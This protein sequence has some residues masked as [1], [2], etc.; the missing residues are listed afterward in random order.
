MPPTSELFE[1]LKHSVLK[2]GLCAMEHFGKDISIETKQDGSKVSAADFAVNKILHDELTPLNK[3]YAWLSEESPIEQN[4]LDASH[5]W[6]IDPIDGTNGFLSHKPDWTIVAALIKENSPVLAAVYNPVKQELYMAEK[7]KGAFLNDHPIKVSNTRKLENAHIISS[8]GH[9]NRSF[10]TEPKPA[11]RSWKH[12]MAY[13]IAL[14]AS[15]TADATISLTPKNDWDIAGAH[16][17]IEEAGGNIGTHKG[18]PLLYN[19]Q[20]IRHRSVV[21]TTNHLYKPIIKKTS[22]AI[23][24]T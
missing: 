20:E 13:R 18:E 2:A 19:K 6:I 10:L 24:E 14:I 3:D 15:G 11:N 22:A 4:R 8:K 21:A 17:I 12:S 16:L 9:F 23:S 1:Q 7:S 5:I